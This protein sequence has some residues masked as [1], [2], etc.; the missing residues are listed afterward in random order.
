MTPEEFRINAHAAVDWVADYLEGIEKYPVKSQVR[1]GEIINQLPTNPPANPESFESMMT[2]VDKIILPGITHWQH[3]HFHA[4]F[5]A[6]SSFPSIIGEILTAGIGAQCMVW[7]TSPAAAEL[8]ERMMEW[9]KEM[10]FLPKGWHGVIEDTASTATLCALLSARERIT[11]INQKGFE[12]NKLRVYCSAEAHSSVAKAVKIAGIGLENMVMIPVDESLAMRP[13]LLNEALVEDI[14]NGFHPCCVISALGS[15]G[16]LAFDPTEAI[17]K[18]CQ[19]HKVWFHVDAA[20]AGN[21]MILP[22][23]EWLREGLDLADS[24]VFNPHKWMMVNFD[25]S[26]YY[27]K[28]KQALIQTFE[29]LP[30]YLKTKTHG[31]VN[32]YRDWGVQLGRRFRALKLWFVIRT[33]GVDG[34]RKVIR[35]HCEYGSWFAEQVRQDP[36][37][38]LI[39]PPQLNVVVLRYVDPSKSLEELNQ[40]NESRL[41][42]INSSGKAFLSHTKVKG[43][44]AIRVVLGQTNLSQKQTEDLWDM[45]KCFSS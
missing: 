38:E 31:E 5:P 42:S 39:T 16:T 43:I 6:N 14:Q 34:I 41:Q 1:P 3:P 26:V 9:L 29:I 17:G 7:E 12:H 28:D 33:Y 21:A 19:A 13:E 27:V 25:C 4:Y 44:Y 2:D 35:S 8:E 36:N 22:E 15:T 40:L 10:M 20:Y 23:L 24:F 11:N 45:L 32:D 37:F 30:E 18:I